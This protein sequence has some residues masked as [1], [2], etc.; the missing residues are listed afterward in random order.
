M[1]VNISIGYEVNKTLYKDVEIS[2]GMG[3]INHVIGENGTGKST[4]YKTLIGELKPLGGTVPVEVKKNIAIISDYISLPT[5]L[6]VI[7]ILNFIDKH[8]IDYM[9]KNFKTI[10][11]IIAGIK[12]QR[13][14]QLSTGQKRIVEIFTAL[15]AKKSILILDEACNGLDYKNR[16]F[17]IKNIKD[18]VKQ[19]KV[20]ILHTSHN[21]EDVIEL[22]G[23]V[24]VLDK[25]RKK[26]YKY[27]G[28]MSM[29][30]LSSFLRKH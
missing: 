22:G 21:L 11:K 17:F 5:E 26:F 16:D 30:E 27:T 9:R 3:E 15:S 2:F 29:D 25:C 7:D 24:Y 12:D 28:L 20:S 14:S 23:T 19:N 10:M 8:N 1:D 18:L 6:K 13:I 4:L